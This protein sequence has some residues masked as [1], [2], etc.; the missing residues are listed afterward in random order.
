MRILCFLI[1]IYFCFLNSSNLK[2]DDSF[3][4][5]LYAFNRGFDKSFLNP[6]L[7]IYIKVCPSFLDKGLEN[8]FKTMSEFNNV[9]FFLIKYNCYN[10]INSFYR[11]FLN[12][13]FGFLGF[14]DVA[15][16]YNKNYVN[17]DFQAFLFSL[18]NENIIY[19]IMPV[20]GPSTLYFN[21]GV[22]ISHFLNPFFY[23]FD[24]MFFYY[25][26]EI[27]NKKSVVFFDINFFHSVMLDGY[28]FLKDIYIQNLESVFN[29]DV[30]S[31]FIDPPE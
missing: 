22:L 4:R 28:T 7:T 24:C 20:I 26:F 5:R 11:F 30:D 17:F 1:F 19:M 23:F 25:F 6:N 12:F 14:L 27:L 31:L 16:F 18:K 21:F 13:Y 10:I 15:M 9:C 3:N 2:V 8:F 29:L